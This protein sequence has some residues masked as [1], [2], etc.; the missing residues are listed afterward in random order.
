MSLRPLGW[1]GRAPSTET[2]VS[3]EP[4]SE[5]E[6]SFGIEPTSQEGPE[7]F[8]LEERYILEVL[9]ETSVSLTSRAK[10]TSEK[11][12]K[13]TLNFWSH[14]HTDIKDYIFYGTRHR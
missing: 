14:Y 2:G 11:K 13:K 8:P 12:K 5:K 10:R 1:V 7:G 9:R 3:W 4:E 6:W